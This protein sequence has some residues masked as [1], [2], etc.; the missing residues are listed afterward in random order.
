MG[1]DLNLKSK[2]DEKTE[3]YQPLI[4]KLQNDWGSVSR[5]CIPIGH[6]G[7]LLGETAHHMAAALATKRPNVGLKRFKRITEGHS[8]DRHA[9]NT[10]PR[11]PNAYYNTFPARQPLDYYTSLLIAKPRS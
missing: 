6:T 7:T 10:T 5:V 3:R 1:L 8:T 11:L 4:A 9:F 2:L